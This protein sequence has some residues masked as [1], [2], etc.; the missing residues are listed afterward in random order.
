M[1]Q[2]CSSEASTGEDRARRRLKRDASA[3]FHFLS[4]QLLA[5]PFE[6]WIFDWRHRLQSACE[7]SF[8]GRVLEDSK[9]ALSK[10]SDSSQNACESSDRSLSEACPWLSKQA[11]IHRRKTDELGIRPFAEMKIC[12]FPFLVLMGI[13]RYWNCFL[14]CEAKEQMEG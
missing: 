11:K 6:D 10:A 1:A 5:N 13:H 4:E 12:C 3:A 8:L 9:R 7:G 2:G 14:M